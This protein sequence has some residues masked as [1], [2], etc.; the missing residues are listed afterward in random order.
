VRPLYD[1]DSDNPSAVT[2][3]YVFSLRHDN[4][5]TPVLSIFGGKITTY[6]QLA[7]H[8]IRDLAPFF[9]FRAKA[10]ELA[11]LPGG[12]IG[13]FNEFLASL[14]LRNPWLPAR[15]AKRLARAYGGRVNEILRGAHSLADLG[16][17]FGADLY[18]REV[19]FLVAKEWARSAEDVLW[20][21]SKLGLHLNDDQVQTFDDWFQRNI[22]DL[23]PRQPELQQLAG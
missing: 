12:D 10:Q 9:K 20:R 16:Q 11:P 21:R 23:S 3:D 6:R 2:R 8:A 13:D 5:Q 22:G 18:Q 15:M 7:L 17:H 19:E 14:Q 1:D 4:G